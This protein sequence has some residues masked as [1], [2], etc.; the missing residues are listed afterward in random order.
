MPACDGFNLIAKMRQLHYD[1]PFIMITGHSQHNE[2][3]KALE[4]G[5]VG[6]LQKP[7]SIESLLELITWDQK[8]VDPI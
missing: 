3:E 7:F 5:A 4:M 2:R 8:N 6:F 1:M